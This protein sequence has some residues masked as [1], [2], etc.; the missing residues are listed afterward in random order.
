MLYRNKSNRLQ[1]LVVIGFYISFHSV[2]LG[3]QLSAAFVSC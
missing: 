2:V 3:D 1:Q